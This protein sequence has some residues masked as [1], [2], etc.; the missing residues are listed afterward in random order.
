MKQEVTS[1]NNNN[2]DN[3][4]NKDNNV[5]KTI[6]D[7]PDYEVNRIGEVRS[8]KRNKPRILKPR[9]NRYG[10][11]KVNLSKN[12]KMKTIEVHR[13]VAEAFIM[14]PEDKPQ[15]NHIDGNKLNNHVSNLEWATRSENIRHAYDNGLCRGKGG[16]LLL[17]PSQVHRI[18]KL[19]QDG[20]SSRKVANALNV[21]L[22]AVKHIRCG[23]RWTHISEHYTW[24][25]YKQ[26]TA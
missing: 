23:R 21:G 16:K 3:K 20:L 25:S 18:C 17:V 15:V 9:A 24:K 26:A 1:I 2:K 4:D 14:N 10:Y 22:S 12:G 5:F 13:L 8:F 6:K 19:L 11:L 7:F